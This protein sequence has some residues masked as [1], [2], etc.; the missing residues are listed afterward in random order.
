MRAVL[1]P[2]LLLSFVFISACTHKDQVDKNR[3]FVKQTDVKRCGLKGKV[4]SIITYKSSLEDSVEHCNYIQRLAFNADGFLVGE[5]DT[6]GRSFYVYKDIYNKDGLLAK[7]TF[8]ASEPFSPR[9]D[10]YMYSY[11]EGK[12]TR[13]TRY[14]D[15]P[16]GRVDTSVYLYDKNGNEIKYKTR[17]TKNVNKYD[18][19]GFLISSQI[20]RGDGETIETVYINDNKGRIL[21]QT[22]S[23]GHIAQAHVYNRDGNEIQQLNYDS[24]G[25]KT[26]DYYTGYCEFDKSGNYLKSISFSP[27]SKYMGITRRVIE[28]Y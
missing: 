11:S 2:G 5:I 24:L 13:I 14:L 28:Y 3:R 27:Q 19:H 12:K 9:V 15:S 8:S 18:E 26:S 21:K 20:I 4:K 25:R 16:P 1:I 17:N 6:V 23:S 7:T 10:T 22:S